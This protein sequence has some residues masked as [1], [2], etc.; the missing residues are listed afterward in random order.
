MQARPQSVSAVSVTSWTFA[1]HGHWD[2][3]GGAACEQFV[4][5]DSDNELMPPLA[6]A[7]SD[8]ELELCSEDD[9]DFSE[10]DYSVIPPMVSLG[11]ETVAP[12]FVDSHPKWVDCH[13]NTVVGMQEYL[14]QRGFSSRDGEVVAMEGDLCG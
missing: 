14:W 13:S 5:D 10:D 9:T 12:C 8:D 2:K 6:D 4:E 11:K 3:H 7:P 1:S